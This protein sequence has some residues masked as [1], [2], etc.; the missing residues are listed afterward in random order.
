MARVFG[1]CAL[2]GTITHM[3]YDMQCTHVWV[4][5]RVNVGKVDVTEDGLGSNP[6]PIYGY[7]VRNVTF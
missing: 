6:L 2:H 7:A 5:F 4:I 3:I 1:F